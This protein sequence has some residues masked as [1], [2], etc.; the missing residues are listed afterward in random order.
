MVQGKTFECHFAL[1]ACLLLLLFVM[2]PGLRQ[3]YGG[4]CELDALCL[5][6]LRKT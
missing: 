5:A 3:L 1:V 2:L 4:C 6:D